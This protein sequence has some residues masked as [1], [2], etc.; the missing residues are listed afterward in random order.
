MDIAE[1]KPLSS[2]KQEAE[3]MKGGAREGETTFRATLPVP[4]LFQPD[5]TFYSEAGARPWNPVTFLKPQV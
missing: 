3:R 4:C 2:C 5:P 1:E